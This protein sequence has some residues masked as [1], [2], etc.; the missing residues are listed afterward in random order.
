MAITPLPT[1]PSRS[2]PANFADRGD[3]FLGA[4]PT[5]VTEANALAADVSA[6]EAAVNAIVNVT[7]WVSGT[8]YTIGQAVYSPITFL[9]YRRKTNG[10]G[11]TDPSADTTNW[12][13]IVGTGNVTETGT[14]VLTN[15]TLVDPTITGAIIEDIFTITDAAAF[16]I[17]PGNGSIQLITLGASRTP[18]ATSFA[19][20]ETVTLMVND[21]TAF[22]LTWTDATFGGSGVVWKTNG[23]VAPTLNLTGF[24]IIVLWKVSNQVYGARVGNA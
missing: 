11:T 12:S 3:A 21:G 23:G 10:A 14:Q 13:L 7:L 24:T 6:S 18:K 22:T 8:S 5:F 16:E 19:N 15:K 1:P 2:D 17:N 20:G 4:L 9:T